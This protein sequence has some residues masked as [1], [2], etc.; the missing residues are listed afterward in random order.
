MLLLFGGAFG[1]AN[2][3]LVVIRNGGACHTDKVGVPHLAVVGHVRLAEN[4]VHLEE[5]FIEFILLVPRQ[6]VLRAFVAP[7]LLMVRSFE[8]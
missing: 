1:A 5:K 7:T 6:I 2:D 8:G 4:V 3:S